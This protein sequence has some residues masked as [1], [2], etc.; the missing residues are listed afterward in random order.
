[1][2]GLSC[3][4]WVIQTLCKASAVGFNRRTLLCRVKDLWSLME[5]ALAQIMKLI[6]DNLARRLDSYTKTQEIG[7]LR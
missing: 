2:A 5:L 6:R 4:V 7:W 3:S 1:M